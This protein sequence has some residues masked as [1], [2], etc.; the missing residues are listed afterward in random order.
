V[1]VAAVAPESIA[2][3]IKPFE[4]AL[5][6]Y[7]SSKVQLVTIDSLRQDGYVLTTLHDEAEA[8]LDERIEQRRWKER[9][10]DSRLDRAM[11]RATAVRDVEILNEL[12]D[13]PRLQPVTAVRQSDGFMVPVGFQPNGLPP[14]RPPGWYAMPMDNGFSKILDKVFA[15]ALPP[16]FYDAAIEI[17]RELQAPADVDALIAGRTRALALS[18]RRAIASMRHGD[19]ASRE[20]APAGDRRRTTE[21]PPTSGR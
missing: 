1:T 4:A 7:Y 5:Y 3:A 11:E 20:A 12:R 15:T 9:I 2:L 8:W 14:D 10:T 6:A 17:V 21:A 18:S 13:D 19:A 16:A